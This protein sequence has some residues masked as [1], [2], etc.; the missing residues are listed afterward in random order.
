M[1]QIHF[2]QSDQEIERCF[3]VISQLRPH[4]NPVNFV[5]RIRRQEEYCGYQLAY[6][7]AENSVK[8]V[9]G[10]RI[11]ES[12][13]WGKFLYIDDFITDAGERAQGYGA[14]LFKA[15]LKYARS[16]GCDQLH[17][18]SGVHRFAAH[19]FYIKQQL[20]ISSHHFSMLL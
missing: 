5:D 1:A 9:A 19:R 17:L 3:P 12:L 7:E 10:F 13:A 4:L 15:L 11:S 20:D 18:D 14:A 6:L 16:Q 8:S 2:A